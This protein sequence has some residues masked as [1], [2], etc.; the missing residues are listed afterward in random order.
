MQTV[1]KGWGRYPSVSYLGSVS[2]A[3][4]LIFS[5]KGVLLLS[6]T[7]HGEARVRSHEV[8]CWTP[9]GSGGHIKNL[10]TLK[11]LWEVFLDSQG[12]SALRGRRRNVAV[13]VLWDGVRETVPG[14]GLRAKGLPRKLNQ[15]PL[16]PLRHFLTTTYIVSWRNS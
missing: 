9:A 16:L 14:K 15:H 7:A 10:R 13:L 6:Q 4:R 12:D 8:A 5:V 11:S 3:Q 2:E 1:D